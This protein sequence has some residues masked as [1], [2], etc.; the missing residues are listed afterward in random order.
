[1]RVWRKCKATKIDLAEADRPELIAHQR[2]GRTVEARAAY[3][4]SLSA[5]ERAG[6]ASTV[7]ATRL[8]LAG[9]AQAFHEIVQCEQAALHSV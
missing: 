8:N 9:I 7:A 6:D 2:A 3:E 5:A 1:M 4:A